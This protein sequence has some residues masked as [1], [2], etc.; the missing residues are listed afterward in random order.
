MPGQPDWQRFQS[1]SGPS[2]YMVTGVSPQL[3]GTLFAGPWR[4]FFMSATIP[5]GTG[6]WQIQ[7]DYASDAANTNIIYTTKTIVGGGIPRIGWQPIVAQYMTFTVTRLVGSAGDTISVNVVPSLLDAPQASRIITT[8]FVQ[9]YEAILQANFNT[10][11]TGSYS[12]PGPAVLTVRSN[13]YEMV[14][15]LQSMN[16]A[17]AYINLVRYQVAAP[18]QLYQYNIQLPDAPVRVIPWNTGLHADATYDVS[19]YPA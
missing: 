15:D 17:G 7:V 12:C 14:Y 10:T 9:Q 13:A 18:Q 2:L 4:S 19:L 3:S 11:I 6:V 8:P 1:S 5:G 16:A